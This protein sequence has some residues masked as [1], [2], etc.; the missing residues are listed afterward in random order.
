MKMI[1]EQQNLTVTSLVLTVIQASLVRILH[2]QEPKMPLM[3]T[4]R[5]VIFGIVLR[6]RQLTV[7]R[8]TTMTA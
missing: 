8:Q 6:I 4:L 7:L 1:S 5:P 3:P 2:L